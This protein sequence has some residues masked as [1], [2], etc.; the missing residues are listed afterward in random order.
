MSCSCIDIYDGETA[1]IN[2]TYTRKARK[3]HICYECRRVIKKGETYTL[4]DILADSE[5]EHYKTCSDCISLR[6]TYCSFYFGEVWNML[7]EDVSGNA[8]RYDD[9]MASRLTDS[10]KLKFFVVIESVWERLDEFEKR[11]RRNKP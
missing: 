3:E 6:D 8:G 4:D 7:Y 2:E 5:W 1:A 10:A 11:Y 9:S